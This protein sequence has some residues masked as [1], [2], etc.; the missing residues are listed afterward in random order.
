VCF[1]IPILILILFLILFLILSI[2]NIR[3]SDYR[4]QYKNDNQKDFFTINQTKTEE[5]N[6]FAI[7]SAYPSIQLSSKQSVKK[8]HVN[9]GEKYQIQRQ[10][11]QKF[12]EL[13]VKKNNDK[14]NFLSEN[15]NRSDHGYDIKNENN[16]DNYKNNNNHNTSKNKEDDDNDDTDDDV[17]IIIDS[18]SDVEIQNDTFNKIKNSKI[19]KFINHQ[20]SSRRK[21]NNDSPIEKNLSE[22]NKKDFKNQNQNSKMM[23]LTDENNNMNDIKNIRNCNN[24]NDYNEDNENEKEIFT[25]RI[26]LIEDTPHLL[27][28]LFNTDNAGVKRGSGGGDISDQNSRLEKTIKVT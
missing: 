16:N 24:N 12:S 20:K 25:S 22:K 23:I 28:R 13:T 17:I 9:Y 1:S 4:I 26:I 10:G 8:E 7:R 19:S 18:D 11:E 27:Q 21:N 5:L 3:S 2:I 6:E 14:V 15:E